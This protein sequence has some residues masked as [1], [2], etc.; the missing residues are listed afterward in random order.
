[1][2]EMITMAHPYTGGERLVTR[3]AYDE[4]WRRRGWMV[5]PLGPSGGRSNPGTNR[6]FIAGHSYSVGTGAGGPG[7]GMDD[8]LKAA[9]P[10][11]D[12][13]F[14]SFTDGDV[15]SAWTPW[16][17]TWAWSGGDYLKL[18][19]SDASWLRNVI[20]VDTGHC[21]GWAEWDL[22]NGQNFT[23][24]IVCAEDPDNYIAFQFSSSFAA[25]ALIVRSDGVETTLDTSVVSIVSGTWTVHRAGN[26]I[27]LRNTTG[28]WVP[29]TTSQQTDVI[30][31]DDTPNGTRWGLGINRIGP[32]TEQLTRFYFTRLIHLGRSGAAFSM[33]DTASAAYFGNGTHADVLRVAPILRDDDL[34]VLCWGIND[35][36]LGGVT[37]TSE[38]K[39]RVGHAL[40]T[41]ISYLLSKS[42][43]GIHDAV[44]SDGPTF[45]NN[46]AATTGIGSGSQRST[47]DVGES[48]TVVV[49]V[50]AATWI[51][52]RFSSAGG[53]NGALISFT[54]NG[55]DVGT[56]ETRSLLSGYAT[57]HVTCTKRILVG[58]GS[59]TIVCTM[60]AGEN[61]LFDG[62]HLE[63]AEDPPI[64]VCNVANIIQ[65]PDAWDATTFTA[66]TIGDSSLALTPDAHIGETV[67]IFSGTGAGQSRTITTNTATVVTVGVAW[68]PVPDA[69]SDF[70]IQQAGSPWG[71]IDEQTVGYY[72][73]EY[74]IVIGEFSDR[75][76]S[77]VDID[78]VLAQTPANFNADELHP[79]ATGAAAIADEIMAVYNEDLGLPEDDDWD[80]GDAD[81]AD[82][83]VI[84]DFGGA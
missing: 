32:Y 4:V 19:S 5:G 56:L 20:T 15:P 9:F 64:A 18:D 71:G 1:M 17:G 84:V 25:I 26:R 33:V 48:I 68:S 37:A 77:I 79:S 43:F 16:G 74:G 29:W 50:E 14:E 49:N 7:F 41:V 62:W 24:L 42:R 40:R 75:R 63:D 53:A 30:L 83:S 8:N 13:W 66:T 12:T 58:P 44:Y 55:E 60:D 46:T 11:A 81:G 35:A 61:M 70:I 3:E 54:R 82:A 28:G 51:G 80:G 38:G 67:R 39:S 2:T 47:Q 6:L 73:L 45:Q 72:N 65:S 21:E 78:A 31:P 76:V 10:G 22:N 57:R 34:A 59:H 23:R 27:R 69:T 52:L 36:I